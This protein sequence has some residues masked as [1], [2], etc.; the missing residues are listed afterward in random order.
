MGRKRKRHSYRKV[1]SPLGNKDT[2][3]QQVCSLVLC[4]IAK[5]GEIK[6]N[7]SMGEKRSRVSLS[8]WRL[9]ILTAK[10]HDC[11]VSACTQD[12]KNGGRVL[13]V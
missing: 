6:R 10:V 1:L 3:N 12:L 7:A 5:C 4:F 11:Q 8:S 9:L 13:L 2:F